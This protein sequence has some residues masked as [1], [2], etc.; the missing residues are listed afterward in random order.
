[1]ASAA[2]FV[3]PL[4]RLGA[5]A[6]LPL[7]V[8]GLITGIV[9]ALP[10]DPAE[11]ICP[12]GTC[13]GTAAL[14]GRW[15]LDE[16]PWAFYRWWLSAAA[17]GDFGRSWRVMQGVPVRELLDGAVP[18]TL[19]LVGV[20]GLLVLAGVGLAVTGVAGR[21]AEV[22]ASVAGIAPVVLL[23]LLGAAMVELRYGADAFVDEAVRWRL[24]AAIGVLTVADG[25]LGLAV[26]GARAVITA[27]RHQR[28]VAVGELR[29]E[30]VLA[31][32]LPNVGPALAGQLRARFVHL[33]SGA[34]V[35]EVV[36]RLD[37]VGD[38]LWRATLLQDFGVVLAAAT[39]FA[40][41][42][43]VALAVQAAVEL[44]LGWMIRRSPA[45][46]PPVTSAAPRGLP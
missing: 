31:N 35:V 30:G 45:V 17:Q 27:E 29:G 34:V 19:S 8:P 15:H 20:S 42:S 1:M 24:I 33:L 26:G 4:V 23:A 37:G 14:A 40:V 12:P 44:G 3:R 9:W 5:A 46:A 10:G 7:L 28:Y 25:A 16:G 18:V 39:F 11:I 2:W 32:V 41:L 21:R 13:S 36:L 6:M 43:G 38:L 22:V